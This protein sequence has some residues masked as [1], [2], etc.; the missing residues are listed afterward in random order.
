MIRWRHAR[1]IG[2]AALP[3]CLLAVSLLLATTSASHSPRRQLRPANPEQRLVL[4]ATPRTSQQHATPTSL[5]PAEASLHLGSPRSV[6]L[7]FTTAWLTCTYHRERCSRIPRALPAYTA[8][9][10]RVWEASLPTPA[11]LAARPAIRS[12]SVVEACGDEAVAT[13]TYTAGPSVRY[14]LHVDLVRHPAGWR[15]FDVAEAPP[16]IPLPAPLNRG[17]GAC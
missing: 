8:A 16:H 10:R 14:Q 3:V 17:P 11:E 5:P 9:L 13:V 12:V 1:H 4:P 15:V 6:A 7:R 2:A